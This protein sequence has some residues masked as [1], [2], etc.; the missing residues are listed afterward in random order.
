MLWTA[1]SWT[2]VGGRKRPWG[3]FRLNTCHRGCRGPENVAILLAKLFRENRCP[4]LG[5]WCYGSAQDR[6]LQARACRSPSW[7]GRCASPGKWMSS[8]D[9]T[10]SDLW[11][12]AF[13]SFWTRLMSKDAWPK[14]IFE[15]CVYSCTIE[16]CGARL[17][18][19]FFWEIGIA[20]WC[21]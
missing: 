17:I 12:P 16:P 7:R 21:H 11:E 6:R 1:T 14:K 8:T 2:F 3:W 20:T 18:W 9:G 10:S 5:R 15:R 13:L 19:S 4:N